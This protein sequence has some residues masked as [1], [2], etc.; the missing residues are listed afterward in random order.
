MPGKY[1]VIGESILTAFFEPILKRLTLAV[2]RH[3]FPSLGITV[4]ITLLV[5]F[6]L[7]N[8]WFGSQR[9][10]YSVV[11]YM[12][13][14]ADDIEYILKKGVDDSNSGPA[15]I[16]G[17]ARAGFFTSSD[18]SIVDRWS[19]DFSGSDYIN[20]RNPEKKFAAILAARSRAEMHQPPFQPIGLQ[21]RA[22]S[23]SCEQ[24]RPPTGQVYV[25]ADS[26]LATQLRAGD[27]LKI[28]RQDGIGKPIIGTVNKVPDMP[29][30]TDIYL[31]RVQMI[32]FLAATSPVVL[33]RAIITN[34][35]P[36][37]G[38]EDRYPSDVNISCKHG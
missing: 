36:N 21:G 33:I 16:A 24:T 23:P 9:S 31:N 4:A 17:A 29:K 15:L 18:R 19:T 11:A 35:D 7:L 27:S 20:Q 14:G 10:K 5:I 6:L 28:S 8:P 2:R 25:R 38:D 13:G 3:V 30:D 1:F 26:Y 12:L 32:D 34:A 37:Q 22:S